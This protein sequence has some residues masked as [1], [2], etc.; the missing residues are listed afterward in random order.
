[1]SRLELEIYIVHGCLNEED[2]LNP[3]ERRTPSPPSSTSGSGSILQV[4]LADYD[5]GSS[6][7]YLLTSHEAETFQISRPRGFR[8]KPFFSAGLSPSCKSAFFLSKKS[9][10]IYS[11]STLERIHQADPLHKIRITSEYWYEAVLSESFLAIITDTDLKIFQYGPLCGPAGL[12]VGTWSCGLD[13]T[14]H[15]W[16][17]VC[18]AI[19]ETDGQALILLGVHVN[20]NTVLSGSIK[21]FRVRMESMGMTL[22]KHSADFNA[23]SPDT[24]TDHFIKDFPKKV[25]FSSDGKS[26]VCRTNN[27]R[28]LT[29]VLTEG[30]QPCQAPFRISRKY[31]VVNSSS[32]C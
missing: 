22:T 5:E 20:T 2:G 25:G 11:L 27:N 19:H 32:P 26:V 9:I 12:L 4:N 3:P 16:N 1:M 23:P 17:P 6:T 30:A 18:V 14:G 13:S 31:T 29:W 10:M 24:S 15:Q 7:S 28:V 21:M 8:R